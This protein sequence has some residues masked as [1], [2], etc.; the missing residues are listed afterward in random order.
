MG[1]FES[2]ITRDHVNEIVARTEELV[3]EYSKQT[4]KNWQMRRR[5][6]STL[7]NI[8]MLRILTSK[9]TSKEP[10]KPPKKK[11]L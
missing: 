10:I 9:V 4:K 11:K 5:A 3:F 8:L 1:Y 6:C 2:P 7:T